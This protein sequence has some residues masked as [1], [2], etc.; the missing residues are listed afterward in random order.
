MRLIG[1][2]G[3]LLAATLAAP[4]FA[5]DAAALKELTPIGKLRIAVAVSPAPS[6]LY[7]IKD[8]TGQLR[9]VTIDLGNALARKLGVAPQF[10]SFLASG[11]IQ[12]SAADNV[13]DVT[14]MPVDQERKKFVDFGDAYHL[15]Q[16][17]YLVAPGS[18]LQA[19][20]DVN[21]AGVRIAG[22]AD[23]ATFRASMK[24]SPDATPVSVAG[25]DAAVAL[26]RAGGADAIALS[27][28][29]LA[30]LAGKI[31]GSRVL[32]GGFLNSTTAIAV[33]RDHPAALAYVTAF[34]EEEKASGDV[35]RFFDEMGLT[36]S[37]VAPAG[38][39]P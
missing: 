20:A 14:F 3:A 35:R 4:A 22:V 29:S 37:Q 17:T 1:L 6:A 19:I 24:A 34:I 33:P 38:M 2:F 25:V 8:A 10:V 15:L 31:P 21:A 9:G 5:D 27:R 16:S 11:E 28:E 36:T 39:K 12:N 13:W 32:D 30:T 7:A 26:M 18:K 23:T